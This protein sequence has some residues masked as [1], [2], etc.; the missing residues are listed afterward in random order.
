[1]WV[2]LLSATNIAQILNT[3]ASVLDEVGENSKALTAIEESVKI[4]RQLA[5][6][7]PSAF[8]RLLPTLLTIALSF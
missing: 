3:H 2:I 7:N 4:R 5:K 1:M 8:L 6:D